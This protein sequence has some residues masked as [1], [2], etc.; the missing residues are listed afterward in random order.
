MAASS[1]LLNWMPLTHDMGL[2]GF[3]LTGVFGNLDQFVIPTEIF[4]K[5]PIIWLDNIDKYKITH[6]YSPNFGYRYLLSSISNQRV[7]SWDLS[8]LQIVFN[9]A[10][11]ISGSLCDEFESF[12][13]KFQLKDMLFSQRMVLQ[14]LP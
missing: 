5:R 12:F 11:T 1:K 14:K 8:S 3:H 13:A 2:I 4:I 7:Y 10:E 6:T 9:G